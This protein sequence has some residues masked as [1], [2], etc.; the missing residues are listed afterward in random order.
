MAGL[1]AIDLGLVDALSRD[2]RATYQELGRTIGLSATA[3][4]DRV[5]RL[6]ST[7]VITGYRAVVDPDRLGRTVEAAID[8][9]LALETDR[10]QFAA[11][12]RRHEAVVEAIHVTGHYD[13]QLK[14]F[15]TG[16]AELDDLLS[17]L[18]LEAGV[19][20]SQTRLMLHRIPD[21]N[22]LGPSLEATGRG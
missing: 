20:E 15:C 18:K 11:V 5:R 22:Q 1:D 10:E 16:T 17:T 7:G 4:A 2:G 12:L 19:V 6:Q 9:R 8:V 14:V 13:Y 21:L 3:T